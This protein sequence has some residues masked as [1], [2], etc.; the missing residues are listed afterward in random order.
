MAPAPKPDFQ[1][2]DRP[3]SR[4]TGLPQDTPRDQ[5]AHRS[6]PPR[7]PLHSGS[8]ISS[9]RRTI[10]P[11]SVEFATS[12]AP[13]SPLADLVSNPTPPGQITRDRASSVGER[14]GRD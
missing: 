4:K 3:V 12:T 13:R 9:L 2:T 6:T 5:T 11:G 10:K 8:Q 14:L 1:P 7:L